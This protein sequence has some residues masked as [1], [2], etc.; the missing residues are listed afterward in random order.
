[1]M[2]AITV[3]T[4]LGGLFGCSAQDG[5]DAPPRLEITSPA[6]GT[7][8]DG[9]AVEVTGVVTD[10]HG[11]V[12]VRI[13]GTEITPA[14]DGTFT[15][16]VPVTA[17]ISILETH[18]IDS[19]NHDVRDVRAVLAGTLAASDGTHAAPVGARVGAQALTKLGEAI[20]AT[21]KAIDF[22]A[23]GQAMNPVY[24][25]T[26]CLGAKL[27]ITT[28]TL[29]DVGVALAPKAGALTTNV[30]LDN[31]EVKL[32]ANFKVACIGGSTNIT[33]KS[34]HAHLDGDLGLAVTGGKIV[35]SLGSPAVTLGGFSIDIGGVPGAIE[36][37]LKGE[38]R[39]AAESALT[40]VIRDRVPPMANS[41]LAGLTGKPL[42][43][44]L[45]GHATTFAV[46]PSTA[47]L[48]P[49]GLFVAFD[50]KVKVAGGEGGMFLTVRTPMSASL[51]P[52]AGLGVAIADDAVNQLFA[53]LWAAGAIDQT[54]SLDKLAVLGALLDDDAR[55]LTLGLSLPPHRHGRG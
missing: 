11:G 12:K 42:A 18:A 13:N 1:M 27:D 15:A 37:L 2:R 26:G 36:S 24:N 19:A 40:K 34:T 31:V 5:A 7:Q 9:Q 55:S 30:T 47:E 21:A 52:G 29:S 35:T 16:T 48:S 6:R 3:A 28:I 22:T 41:A 8:T 49:Q 23:A 32:H 25:N 45:L 43:T 39:K 50:T 53:G 46:S 20:G 10:D 51:M 54:I 4:L 38:A 33:I 44:D 17:G 14:A